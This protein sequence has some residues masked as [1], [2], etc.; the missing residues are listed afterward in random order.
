[1]NVGIIGAGGIARKLH[2]PQL[3][4]IPDVK[5]THLAGRKPHRLRLLSEQFDVPHWTTDYRDLL[6]D[7]RLDAVIVATPH[8]LHV[9]VGLEVLAAG[10]HLLMQKPLCGDI[11]E[12]NRFV[13][14]VERSDR[15]TMVM[16]HYGAEIF[17]CR[18]LVE[19]GAIGKPSGAHCRVSH[20]GPEVYYAEV[21]DHFAETGD[22]LWFFQAG[23]AA[24]GA[25][26]DMGVYAVGALTAAL[27]SV[28]SV[29]GQ[30]ATLDKPTTL[31]DTATLIL[32]FANG[33]VATAETGWCDPTRT[34]QFR[35]HGTRG[36]LTAPGHDGAGLT[37]WEPGSYT[38]EDVPAR[39]HAVDVSDAQRGN[40]HE[41]WLRCIHEGRPPERS[42]AWAARHIV[43]ILLAGLESSRTGQRISIHSTSERTA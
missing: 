11:D 28:Q 31:E 30:V 38:R 7:D 42:H 34:W 12:A 24:V 23:E 33:V 10:K 1:M 29:I 21:R 22:D 4:D 40:V 26:F 16:P 36:K 3:A 8:P 2:L 6:A 19:A 17:K 5:V 39:P 27:G 43:E 18:E 37:L 32:H 41:Y 9:S 13:D 14:A 35:I 15:T 20:G 25:L